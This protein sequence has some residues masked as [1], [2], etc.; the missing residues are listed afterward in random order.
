MKCWRG[1]K[2]QINALCHSSSLFW[3]TRISL[4]NVIWCCHYYHSSLLHY[5]FEV[6]CQIDKIWTSTPFSIVKHIHVGPPFGNACWSTFWKSNFN[7]QLGCRFD[8][9]DDISYFFCVFWHMQLYM[10]W[11]I[12]SFFGFTF[13]YILYFFKYSC[14]NIFHRRSLIRSTT[15][16]RFDQ[17]VN[18]IP[19]LAVLRM[20]WHSR[21][22]AESRSATVVDAVAF[23]CWH[24][25]VH[26]PFSNSQNICC[27][28]W[29]LV[30]FCSVMS[31]Q[32][33]CCGT[34]CLIV[35]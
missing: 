2:T 11:Y 27:L 29:P 12:I 23:L 28:K 17:L 33:K 14:T 8:I 5:L 7:Q 34:N 6:Q 15:Y 19:E 21:L 32:R 9:M 25:R 31:L 16:I 18:K 4:F 20:P 22:G 30:V 26:M 35:T 24:V 13:L 1:D 3:K 10:S